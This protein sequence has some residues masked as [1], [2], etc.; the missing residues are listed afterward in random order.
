MGLAILDV[1]DEL[2][3]I[4]IDAIERTLKVADK[5]GLN[6]N[7]LTRSMWKKIYTATELSNFENYKYREQKVGE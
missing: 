7:D 3:T 1:M 2:N 6:R 5:Y 4:I